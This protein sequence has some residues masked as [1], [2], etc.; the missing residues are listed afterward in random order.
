MA[1]GQPAT[2]IG[3][4]YYILLLIGMLVHKL[5]DKLSALIHSQNA[6]QIHRAI[7]KF[8]PWAFGVCVTLLVYV[9]ITGLR[10]P[11]F[12]G[13]GSVAYPIDLGITGPFALSVFVVILML[14]YRRAKQRTKL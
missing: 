2:G 3:G 1:V 9:N 13:A 8:P 6:E 4:I 10:F 12:L 14:F 7:Q 11:I 5:L